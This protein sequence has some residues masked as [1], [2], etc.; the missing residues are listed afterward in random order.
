M[1]LPVPGSLTPSKVA[2]FKDCA[3]AFRFSVIDRL[4]EPPSIPALKGT[5]VHRALQGLFWD[6]SP[7]ERTPE[8]AMAHLRAVCRRAREAPEGDELGPAS[9]E[10]WQELEGD[11]EA[12]IARYFQ[13]E[14]P[15]RVT[16]VGVELTLEVRLG[17]LLLRGIIDRLDLDEDGSLVVTDYKT[18][19]VPSQATE[20][21]RLGGVHFYAFL[22]ERVLGVRPAR[23][24]LLYLR[25]PLAISTVPSDHSIRGLQQKTSAIWSAILRACEHDDFRPHPSGLCEYCAFR[26]YCPAWGG[27]PSLA[28]TERE[29]SVALPLPALAVSAAD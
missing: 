21:S 23:V 13:L 3:L 26:P 17:R 1:S 20:Q 14:D 25:E 15:N 18:G 27:D 16:A 4:P 19:R 11:A 5:L 22:C 10:E 24:Q 8:A 2:A 12:M 7:G 9:E 29:A 6:Q 28:V